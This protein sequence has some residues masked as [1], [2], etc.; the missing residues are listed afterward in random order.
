MTASRP[1]AVFFD[2]G[3]TLIFPRVDQLAQELTAQGYPATAEDFYA[4]ERAGKQK[5]ASWLLPQIESGKIPRLVD[6]TYWLEYL[7]ALAERIGVPAGAR[8]QV[9]R[10]VGERFADIEIW[11]RVLPDTPPFLDSQVVGVEKPRPEIFHM[12]LERA[13]VEAR[14]AVFVGDSYATDI[15]GARTAGLRGVLFDDVGVYDHSGDQLD[16]PRI[17]ALPQLAGVLEGLSRSG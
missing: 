9:M 17:T 11:S 4:A 3:N 1:R 8:D 10:G 13:G 5:L 12:A 6:L 2:A 14:E 7:R 16:C 15:A